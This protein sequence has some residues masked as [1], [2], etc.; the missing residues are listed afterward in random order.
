M[1]RPADPFPLFFLVLP[2]DR[3]NGCQLRIKGSP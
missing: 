1:N 2:I 3:L